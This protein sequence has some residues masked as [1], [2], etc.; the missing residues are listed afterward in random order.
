MEK[1]TVS[2][3]PKVPVDSSTAQNGVHEEKPKTSRR[4]KDPTGD[5][6]F[7]AF[8]VAYAALFVASF[9]DRIPSHPWEIMTLNE[10]LAWAAWMI[11]YWWIP[12]VLSGA[13]LVLTFGTQKYLADKKGYDKELRMPLAYWSVLL[14]VFSVAG[15]LRTVPAMLKI[16]ANR[17]VMH[18][19]CGD[20]RYEWLHGTPAG[21]WTFWFCMSKIP[22]LIDTAFIVLR[23]KELITL[24]WYHHFTVMLFCWQAWASCTLNGLIFAAMNLTVHGVMYTFYALAALGYRPNR[25]A[26]FITMG[27]IS[28]MIVGTAVTAYVT[29]DKVLWHPIKEVDLSLKIPTWFTLKDAQP[30][31][32]ECFVSSGNALAGLVMYGSYLLFFVHFFIKAYCLPGGKGE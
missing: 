27:Q 8:L 22:E 15:S 28:Q 26:M 23:K 20:T 29:L 1:V 31:G 10:H 14:A 11:E 17:G 18:V 25:F 21:F 5:I 13:Y 9:Q 2:E 16:T 24:H 32:G 7:S 6:M 3:T 4:K 30:D 12:V 19:V